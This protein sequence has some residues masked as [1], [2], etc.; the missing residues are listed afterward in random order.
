ML[1]KTIAL[2]GPAASGKST[3][4]QM[5]AKELGFLFFDT[6][7][8]YRAITL[9]ALEAGI[10]VKNEAACTQLAEHT[11]IDVRPSSNEDGRSND[12]LIDGV[13][14]T[15]EIRTPKVDANVSIVSA[16]PGV[17]AALTKKQRKIGQRGEVVMVGRDIGTVVMPDAPLKIFLDASAEERARRRYQERLDRGEPANYEQ[18]LDIVK[19]RD[20]I[21]ST[22]DVA[23][24]RA[25]E[26]A[27]IIFCDFINAKEVFDMIMKLAKEKGIA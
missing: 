6:G 25:A 9:A 16:Y 8:M 22:R 4:G 1:F 7:V 2:D 11:Q 12:I 3:V 19:Q 5:L 24:L 15:W 21:D 17:R 14:K 20:Q 27:E 10:S 13:D 26:D 18:V 23:P